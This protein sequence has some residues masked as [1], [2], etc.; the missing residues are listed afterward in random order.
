[1]FDRVVHIRKVRIVFVLRHA[2]HVGSCFRAGI[3]MR[4][5]GEDGYMENTTFGWY[6][7]WERRR[8]VGIL[9]NQQHS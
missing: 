3:N 6:F 9:T 5:G 8:E 1:M 2:S 7:P 4:G